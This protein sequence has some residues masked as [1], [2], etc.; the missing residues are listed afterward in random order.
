MLFSV[1]VPVYNA[2]LTLDECVGSVLGAESRNFELI[3]VNDGSRDNSAAMCD[4]FAARD[5]R[6]AVIHQ[7]NQGLA[8]ARN[9][10]IRAAHGDFL[11]HLDCDDFLIAGWCETIASEIESCPDADVLVW[12]I[13][14]WKNGDLLVDNVSFP[15]DMTGT[16]AGKEAFDILFCSNLGTLWQTFRYVVRRISLLQQEMFFCPGVIHEDV[17]HNP[18]LVLKLGSVHFC[19]DRYYAYRQG[20]KGSITSG[21]TVARCRDMIVI[22]TRWADRLPATNLSVN[23][24]RRFRSV[25]ARLLWDV[26]ANI[27]RF[28]KSDRMELFSATSS[29]VCLL[30][31]NRAPPVSARGKRMLLGLVGV[32]GASWILWWFRRWRRQ[33]A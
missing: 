19:R 7:E 14:L 32:K 15:V 11:V 20:R 33:G 21:Q 30:R 29:Q 2:E 8:C 5:S 12:G 24:Q 22:A 17:D 25:L 27:P 18:F 13:Y 1:I 3:L 28:Q 6:V 16:L 4:A 9:A 31:Q 10:G 23:T 26:V